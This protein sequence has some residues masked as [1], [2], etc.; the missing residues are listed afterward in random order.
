MFECIYVYMYTHTHTYIYA[1]IYAYIYTYI[2]MYIYTYIY[3]QGPL[4]A[5]RHRTVAVF[6]LRMR[7]NIRWALCMHIFK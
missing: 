7:E 1:Y 5:A 2:Y 4:P 6:S 3:I